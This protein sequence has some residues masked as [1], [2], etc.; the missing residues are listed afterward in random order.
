MQTQTAILAWASIAL[1]TVCTLVLCRYTVVGVPAGGEGSNGVAYR[2]DRWTG[3][4]VAIQG[5]NMVRAESKR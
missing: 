3:E 2:L 5:A 4:V 1:L